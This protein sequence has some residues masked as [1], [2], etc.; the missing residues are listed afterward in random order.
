MR[1]RDRIEKYLSKM[2]EGR[3]RFLDRFS[4]LSQSQLDF[5]PSRNAWS[6]GQVA[7]HVGLT[8]E[9]FQKYTRELLEAG[10]EEKKAL[11]RVS[12][13]ELPLG[14]RMVPDFVLRLPFVALPVS[15]MASVTP[16]A[17]F[18][19]LLENPL[20]KLRT[21]PVLEPKRE[22][23]RMELLNFLKRTRQSTLEILEPVQDW[24]LSQFRWEHPLIGNL[25]L[26]GVLDLLASHDERHGRQ[27]DSIKENS[28]FPVDKR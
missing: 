20:L 5:K 21:A 23:D 3:A 12:L 9:L 22:M 11:R 2:Q 4:D 25:D 28:E 6:I 16:R 13:Q 26:Y 1:N 10:G 24:D 15:V 18:S 27:M 7:Q 17:F 14:P 8:E 19:V